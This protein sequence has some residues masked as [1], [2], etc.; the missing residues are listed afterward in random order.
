MKKIVSFL[1]VVIFLS[2]SG[3]TSFNGYI[4]CKEYRPKHM[5]NENVQPVQMAIIMPR[6]VP[7]RPKPYL[8]KSKWVIY[9]ANKN[10]VKMFDVDSLYFSTVRCGQNITINQ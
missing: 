2:C 4:V 5:S 6:P 10:G 3:Q 9:V 8:I 7:Y 1:I